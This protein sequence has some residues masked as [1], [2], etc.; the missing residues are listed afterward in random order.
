MNTFLSKGCR[1]PLPA[2]VWFL[3]DFAR[4][5]RVF[6]RRIRLVSVHCRSM[7]F[8]LLCFAV[9]GML[10][11]RSA[12]LAAAVKPAAAR[13]VPLAR[14]TA[15]ALV[16]ILASSDLT[17]H[18]D[19]YAKLGSA[20]AAAASSS[21]RPVRPSSLLQTTAGAAATR[22]TIDAKPETAVSAGQ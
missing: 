1:S 9:D 21:R 7:A 6:L 4:F 2:A 19:Q 3:S 22:P 17:H 16:S 5:L 14:S 11:P 13:A 10:P 18:T 12:A 20:P 8:G 15:P